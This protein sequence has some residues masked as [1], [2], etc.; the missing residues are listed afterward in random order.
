MKKILITFIMAIIAIS[1]SACSSD[2]D[3]NNEPVVNPEVPTD[4]SKILVAYFSW[5][6]NTRAVATQIAQL[7]G[8]TLY[9]IQPATPYTIDYQTLAYTVARNELDTD[10]RPALKE[11]DA[12]F[13]QYDYV[14]IGCPVWWG[15]APMIMSTFCENYSFNGK[16]V[17]PF[18]TYVSTGRDA[19]LQKLS[20]LTATA[21][22]L[23]GYGT[24]GSNTSGV[25][26]WLK[27]INMIK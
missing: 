23:T 6:G 18:C 17:I 11:T 20:S 27:A 9:E 14:F 8:G 25:E 16:T 4:G 21:N 19:T 10:A 1:F 12:N 13:S 24:N 3:N 2:N 7:T 5:G 15:T 26:S 22:H